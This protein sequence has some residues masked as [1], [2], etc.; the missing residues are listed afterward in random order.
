M[1][2]IS[3]ADF[4]LF[5]SKMSFSAGRMH[6]SKIADSARNSA[7]RICPNLVCVCVCVLLIV[8]VYVSSRPT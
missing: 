6:A 3:V 1:H 7:R 5:C 2:I 4:P 8:R